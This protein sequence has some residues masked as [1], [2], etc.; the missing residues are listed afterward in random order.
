MVCGP[1]HITSQG[2]AMYFITF[3][4][5]YSRYI[6]V[7]FLKAKSDALVVFK[8]YVMETERQTGNKL[9]RLRSDNGT[10]YVNTNFKRF[11]QDQGIVHETTVPYTPQQ[12]GVSE[13][14]N[15]TLMEMSRCLLEESKLPKFL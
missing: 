1:I 8:N 4:D 5:D 13:R 2:G 6:S 3:I 15:R 14:A 7:Y 11:L 10:E 12:N 9:K